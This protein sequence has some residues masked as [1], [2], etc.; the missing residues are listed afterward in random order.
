MAV[1][2]FI[3]SSPSCGVQPQQV[4]Y[5]FF[6]AVFFAAAFLAVFF[7]ATFLAVFFAATFLAVFFAATFLAVF[8]API[9][10]AVSFFAA[11]FFFV[12]T[13]SHLHSV[14]VFGTS[15]ALRRRN[16]YSIGKHLAS[17]FQ[18]N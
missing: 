5:R 8:F 2:K 9:F 1:S 14:I 12:A 10:L 3:E 11:D 17:F 4:S 13:D 18:L 15:M 16:L 6:L 7:A